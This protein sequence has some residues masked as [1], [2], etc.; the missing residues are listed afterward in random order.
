M[1]AV[2]G[3]GLTSIILVAADSGPLLAESVAAAL[4]SD[5]Q[6]EV[7]VVDNA[8]ADGQPARVESLHVGDERLRVV[9]N[10]RNLGFG[11]ACNRGASLA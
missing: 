8:S 7:I 11:P 3:A 5:A 2:A 6:I 1:A 10:D 9:R 4:A